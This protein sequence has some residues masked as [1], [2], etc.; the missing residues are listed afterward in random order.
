[1]TSSWSK[2]IYVE[3]PLAEP[4]D[5]TEL[6]VRHLYGNATRFNAGSRIQYA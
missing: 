1:M 4:N 6:V 3:T 5:L 2:D